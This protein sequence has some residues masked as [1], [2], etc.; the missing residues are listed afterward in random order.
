MPPFKAEIPCPEPFSQGYTLATA[1]SAPLTPSVP[2]EE[3]NIIGGEW[4]SGTAHQRVPHVSPS[5][6]S[7]SALTHPVS[8]MVIRS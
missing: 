8:Y 4:P 2:S 1:L 5:S 6:L 7:P 3:T